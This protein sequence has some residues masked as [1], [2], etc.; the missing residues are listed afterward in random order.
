M[1]GLSESGSGSGPRKGPLGYL[2]FGVSQIGQ[3]CLMPK[4]GNIARRKLL[5]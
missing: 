3:M 5:H 4:Y 2:P 1:K